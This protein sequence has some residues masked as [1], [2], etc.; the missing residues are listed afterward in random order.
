MGFETQCCGSQEM[1]KWLQNQASKVE[2]DEKGRMATN[3]K[4]EAN[5]KKNR[6]SG[7]YSEKV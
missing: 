3:A 7:I 2:K 1:A 4:E 6:A 5:L